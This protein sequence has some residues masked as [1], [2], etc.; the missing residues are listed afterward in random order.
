MSWFGVVLGLFALMAMLEGLGPRRQQPIPRSRRWPN[1]IGVA[2][3]DA[4]LTRIVAPDVH[5][6][7]HS[8][9]Q[10]ET[11]SNFGFNFPWRNSFL[12]THR[13]QPEADC[14]G[15]TMTIDL[16]QFY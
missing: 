3:L 6:V 1:N 2:S 14:R 12:V 13:P 11:V 7:Y 5:P 9:V 4:V 15:M 16:E 8:V 10:R